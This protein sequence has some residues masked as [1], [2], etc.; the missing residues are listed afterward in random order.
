MS[1]MHNTIHREIVGVP[2]IDGVKAKSVLRQLQMLED[3][4]VIKKGDSIEKRLTIL[5]ALTDYLSPETV[6]ALKHQLEIAQRFHTDEP[7]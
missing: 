7:S 3:R 5:I 2:P 6:E 1:T 4:K